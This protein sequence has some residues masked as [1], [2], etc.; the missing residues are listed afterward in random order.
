MRWFIL[1]RVQ[2]V[3]VTDAQGVAYQADILDFEGMSLL[4]GAIVPIDPPVVI[5]TLPAS[6]TRE[7]GGDPVVLPMRSYF[8]GD[9]LEFSWLPEAMATIN[10][11]DEVV[12]EVT[13]SYGPS[14]F[15]IRAENS[16]GMRELS[17]EL[18]FT[19]PVVVDPDPVDP[20]PPAVS[21]PVM[22]ARTGTEGFGAAGH[23][24][25]AEAFDG[26]R[27]DSDH[28]DGPIYMNII[29]GDVHSSMIWEANGPERNNPISLL[30]ISEMED[31]GGRFAAPGDPQA[32]INLQ[33][34]YWYGLVA[35]QQGADLILLWH[36]TP[37]SDWDTAWDHNRAVFNFYRQWVSDKIGRTVYVLPVDLY[38]SILRRS[39]TDD[40][41]WQ[42][43]VHLQPSARCG[44][45]YMLAR[46]T[47]GTV[48]PVLGG[49]EVYH[50]AAMEA[51]ANYR[52]GGTGGAGNDQ[53]F[54]ADDPL[55]SPA[56]LP[57]VTPPPDPDPE[58]EPEPEPAVGLTWTAANYS[59]PVLSGTQ[60]TVNGQVMS[61]DG[62]G[63][64]TLE[65]PV[66]AGAYICVAFRF[67]TVV[68]GSNG[69]IFL[70]PD[71]VSIFAD[72]Y[73][74]LEQHENNVT[75]AQWNGAGGGFGISD[76][77]V[78]EWRIVEIWTFDGQQGFS[79]DGSVNPTTPWEGVPHA[80]GALALFPINNPV[81]VLFVRVS[82]VMPSE[83][84]RA[85]QLADL[86][87]M[88][89]ANPSAA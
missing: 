59:G 57:A 31:D 58:P 85:S 65:F 75:L 70:N 51:L 9:D 89:A 88:V 87:A 53:I 80:S 30:I 43:R 55:P 56:P 64:R 37:R 21:G 71:A 73:F 52:W 14:P 46:M 82:P 50:Q 19:P 72:P 38:V 23:S 78:G 32:V 2:E 1:D 67:P 45:G 36:T 77:P 4:T 27:F 22:T 13:Q 61:F 25:L 10:A 44:V 54:V 7:I 39:L 69:F 6:I 66:T 29:G 47:K 62:S 35:A 81:D 16:S 86:R 79:V 11:S 68:T 5:G 17:T 26:G 76:A 33:H 74:A 48:P 12:I 15:I 42:D 41:I 40:E 20:D 60:P 3:W 63:L 34:Q 24:S 8:A 49:E 28:W 84:E 83:A 18:T